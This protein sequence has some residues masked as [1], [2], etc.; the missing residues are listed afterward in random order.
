MHNGSECPSDDGASSSHLAS[1]L[2]PPTHVPTRYF[3]SAK[4]AS[5]I[6]R[7]ANRRGK[8]LPPMLEQALRS[9]ANQSPGTEKGSPVCVQAAATSVEDPKY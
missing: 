6:L 1:I 9:V 7:R 5:G 2:Q 3:L 8:T 4:A